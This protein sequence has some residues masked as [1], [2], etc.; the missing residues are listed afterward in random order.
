M[1][2]TVRVAIYTALYGGYDRLR[3]LPA[4]GVPAYVYTD[5]KSLSVEGWQTR[6]VNHGICT[7]WGASS[8]VAPMMAHKWWKTHPDLACPEADV[9]LWLDS[10]M[11]LNSADYVQKCLGALGTDDW[12]CVKHPAR[13]CVYPEGE[14]S[15]TLTWRYDAASINR[16]LE[17]YRQFYPRRGAPLVAT[18]ANARRHTEAV[19]K[20]S[21]QWW[22]ECVNWSHQDQLSLP[23]LLWIA[24]DTVR[25]N[26]N[27]PW[28]EWW[29]LHPHGL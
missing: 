22:D 15:A 20:V 8:V 18:G 24:G 12:S 23:V 7:P 1:V 13:D 9:S 19:L 2:P 26:M 3:T 4:V 16:Q 17:H 27:L 11:E 5:N 21:H 14:F 28:H 6:Y 10:S 25:W 29:S